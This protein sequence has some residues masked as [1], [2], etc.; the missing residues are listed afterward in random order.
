MLIEAIG[1]DM[2]MTFTQNPPL[3]CIC[4]KSILPAYQRKVFGFF[5]CLPYIFK[6][7]DDLSPVCMGICVAVVVVG[8][9]GVVSSV[10]AVYSSL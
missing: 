9:G 6:E 4:Y 8:G 7:Q 5:L 3:W 1:W 2:E 10:V